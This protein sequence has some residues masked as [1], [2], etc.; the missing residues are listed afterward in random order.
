MYKEVREIIDAFHC[1]FPSV[2]ATFNLRHDGKWIATVNEPA[3][4]KTYHRNT[5][6][7]SGKWDKA[8]VERFTAA[9]LWEGEEEG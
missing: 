4:G 9:N 8:T 5:Y 3:E 6:V 2:K 1:E 7:F